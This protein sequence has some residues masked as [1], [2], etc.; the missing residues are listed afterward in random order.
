MKRTMVAV[1]VRTRLQQVMSRAEGCHQ[2][3][4]LGT[5]TNHHTVS[6]VSEG[7]GTHIMVFPETVMGRLSQHGASS[8]L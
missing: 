3:Q 1:R 4:R 7:R 6:V 2:G 8:L 5:V